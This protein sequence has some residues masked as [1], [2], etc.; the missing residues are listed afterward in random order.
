[1]VA[2]HPGV[3]HCYARQGPLN[4]WF[5]LTLGPDSS[6]GL[7][8][9]ANLLGR[10]AGATI[11]HVL[12]TLKRYKVNVHVGPDGR[13]H[14]QPPPAGAANAP[15]KAATLSDDQRSAVLAFQTDLPMTAEPFA[16]LADQVKLP[17]DRLLALGAQ[18]L[19]AGW[20][21]RYGAVLHHRAAGLRAN[22]LVAWRVLPAY[23]DAAGLAASRVPAVSH[24]YLRAVRDGW[25]YGLY[26]MIHGRTEQDC[27]W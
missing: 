17:A 8:R 14:S 15:A 3:S 23:A 16:V 5:T 24:C 6:L 27:A 9:T 7:E 10:L 13:M 21:R 2:G 12:P 25:P 19:A 18:M 1:M 22:V 20:M 4:L 26:T 11:T